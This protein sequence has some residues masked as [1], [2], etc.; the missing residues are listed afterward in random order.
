[1]MV[2]ACFL[3]LSNCL[4]KAMCLLWASLSAAAEEVEDVV[5][6]EETLEE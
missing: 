1:M 2:S 3:A 5:G 6:G 4:F